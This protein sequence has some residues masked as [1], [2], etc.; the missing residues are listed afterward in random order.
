MPLGLLYD[1]YAC[2]TYNTSFPPL[3]S[4]HCIVEEEIAKPIAEAVWNVRENIRD[5]I[6][7]VNT[8]KPLEGY[9]VTSD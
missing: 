8:A 6:N 5:S 3:T 7:I 4:N 9:Q 2:W 1:Y